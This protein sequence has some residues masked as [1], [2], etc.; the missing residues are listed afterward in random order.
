MNAAD[1]ASA[2]MVLD[3]NLLQIDS[4]YQTLVNTSPDLMSLDGQLT[5]GS[6][7]TGSAANVNNKTRLLRASGLPD[8][9]LTSIPVTTGLPANTSQLAIPNAGTL[10]TRAVGQ[11]RTP[12]ILNQGQT[13]PQ[14]QQIQPVPTPLINGNGVYQSTFPLGTNLINP[15]VI[16]LH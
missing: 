6:T 13:L 3:A 1:F 15:P 7:T 16:A 14:V 12:V 9:L 4:T 11:D 8:Q 10:G 5:T 2:K